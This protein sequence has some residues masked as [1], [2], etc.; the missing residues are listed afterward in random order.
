[1]SETQTAVAPYQAKIA[2]LRE[3]FDRAKPEIEK[4]VPRHLSTDKLLKVAL[5]AAG[6]N[7]MLLQCTPQ[8]ILQGVMTAAQLGLDVGGLLGSAYLVPYKNNKK[9][10][11]TYE[12]QMIVGYRG[13]IDLARRSGKVLDIDAHTVHA[14]DKFELSF[15]TAPN[16]LHVPKLD[17]PAGPVIGAYAIAFIRDGSPHAEFM[18]LEQLEAIRKRSRASDSGPWQTDREEMQ[19]KTVVRR[20]A[21][22]LP[23][24]AEDQLTRAM[25]IEDRAESGA[26]I[27]DVDLGAGTSET[28]ELAD[29]ETAAIDTTEAKTAV[30]NLKET[31]K[32]KQGTLA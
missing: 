26:A 8:S 11:P 1:M 10:P 20:L 28:F 17:G 4:V 22:Y 31:V 6:R 23:L 9:N 7:P 13:M 24:S 32:A 3:L 16:I 2:T 29:D 19:R 27:V 14:G 25:E 30:E 18:T 21:K 12:A 5:V 15:G